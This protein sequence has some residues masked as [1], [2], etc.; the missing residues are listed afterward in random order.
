MKYN[1]EFFLLDWWIFFFLDLCKICLT[2]N[3]Y[4]RWTFF[5]LLNGPDIYQWVYSSW[6]GTRAKNT[7]VKPV[8]ATEPFCQICL[9]WYG[10]CIYI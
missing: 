5:S 10:T 3:S 6:V 9:N 8:N 4:I 7:G 1:I 2:I